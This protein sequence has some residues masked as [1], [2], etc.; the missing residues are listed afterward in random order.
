[1]KGDKMVDLLSRK[2][3]KTNCVTWSISTKSCSGACGSICQECYARKKAFTW[4]V[5]KNALEYRRKWFNNNPDNIV[6]GTIAKK[7]NN[8][9]KNNRVR[10]FESG[11]F[12]NIRAIKIWTRI[13]EKCPNK[14][15]WIPT[16]TWHKTEFL[17][18]LQKLNK[19]PNVVVRPSSLNFDKKAPRVK[20]LAAG[21]MA[22][23]NE[24]CPENY[25]DC[26]GDCEKCG[27][28]WNKSIKVAYHYH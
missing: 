18:F 14:R 3:P 16:R 11:D 13:A 27:V 19:L 17:P 1:M 24:N 23:K 6:V 12:E 22:Y 26:K 15:F 28:C 20:G 8:V 5:V 9:R 4:D 7:L 10:V 25:F 2:N 21:T